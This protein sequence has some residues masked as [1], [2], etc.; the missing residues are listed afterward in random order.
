MTELRCASCRFWQRNDP[1]SKLGRCLLMSN[2]RAAGENPQR[3]RPLPLAVIRVHPRPAAVMS[4]LETEAAF[5]CVQWE[6]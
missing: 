2:E 6:P 5:G 1:D 4:A 3:K